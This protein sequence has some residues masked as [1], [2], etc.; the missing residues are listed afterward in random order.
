MTKIEF[1]EYGCLIIKRVNYKVKHN[2]EI[3]E[4]INNIKKKDEYNDKKLTDE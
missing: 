4:L 3:E 2:E 1:D